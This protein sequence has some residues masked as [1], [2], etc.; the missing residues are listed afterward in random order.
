MG[1]HYECSHAIDLLK[2]FHYDMSRIVS[3]D[4]RSNRR[5]NRISSSSSSGCVFDLDDNVQFHETN[6][7][8]SG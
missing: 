5:Q 6:M 1:N 7:H 3:R 2:Y 4:S 8:T